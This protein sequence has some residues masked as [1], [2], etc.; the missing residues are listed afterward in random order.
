MEFSAWISAA[1]VR[2]F[3]DTVYE[4]HWNHYKEEFGST[5]AGF[6]R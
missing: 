6:F 4:P 3:L 1:A 2:F 5:F